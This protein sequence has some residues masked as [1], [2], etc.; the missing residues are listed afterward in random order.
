MSRSAREAKANALLVLDAFS[1]KNSPRSF[2][3]LALTTFGQ[4]TRL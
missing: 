1:I 2:L 4:R 3:V